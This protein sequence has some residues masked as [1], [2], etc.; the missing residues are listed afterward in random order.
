MS[1]PAEDA[2]EQLAALIAG[3]VREHPSVH[4]LHAGDF[5]VITTL[6]PGRRLTGVRMGPTVEIAVVARLDRPLPQVV[7]ELRERVQ[8]L[9]GNVPVDVT[10]ADVHSEE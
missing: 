1:A 3:S 7:A 4:R 5:G 8:Q 6:A 9:A 2:T 10:I